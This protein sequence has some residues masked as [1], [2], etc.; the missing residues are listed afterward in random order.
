[1][2]KLNSLAN[3][4]FAEKFGSWYSHKSDTR[5]YKLKYAAQLGEDLE[6]LAFNYDENENVKR[7]GF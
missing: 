3:M 6:R 1:M 2:Y 7:H 4:R 5:Y